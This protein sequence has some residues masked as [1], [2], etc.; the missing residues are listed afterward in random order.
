MFWFF[1]PSAKRETAQGGIIKEFYLYNYNINIL[2]NMVL[3][4]KFDI[5]KA[6]HLHRN[7]CFHKHQDIVTVTSPWQ[8]LCSWNKQCSGGLQQPKTRLNSEYSLLCCGQ[9]C[10][11]EGKS[12]AKWY[13]VYLLSVTVSIYA[14]LTIYV[15]KNLSLKFKDLLKAPSRAEKTSPR[16]NFSKW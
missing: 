13:L 8:M 12:K 2:P 5:R 1:V 3:V 15:S 10:Q 14:V 9:Q 7:I 4:K 16:G 6:T 11:C